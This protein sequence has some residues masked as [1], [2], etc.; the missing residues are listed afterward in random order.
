MR[1]AYYPEH[2]QVK[3][4]TYPANKE[5]IRAQTRFTYAERSATYFNAAGVKVLDEDHP[6]WMK[7]TEEYCIKSAASGDGCTALNDEVVTTYEYDHPN[8]LMTGM[9][10]QTPDGTRRT[11]YR[12]DKFGNQIGVTTPLGNTS[13]SV[14]PGAGVTP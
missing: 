8:L 11:C 12:Y 14:C 4:I 10:V 6:I 9:A 7:I 2:G 1:L 13:V 5:G 3:S